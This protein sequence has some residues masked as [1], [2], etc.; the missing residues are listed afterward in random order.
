MPY[1]S[2]E[3]FQWSF[4]GGPWALGASLLAGAVLIGLSYRLTLVRLPRAARLALSFLRFVAV[5]LILACICRPTV[6]RQV[7]SEGDEKPKVAVVF[8]E[9][10]S[11]DVKSLWGQSRRDK[12]L[13]YWA[14]R[15]SRQ[16]DLYELHTYAFAES[17][18]TSEKPG[19]SPPPATGGPTD[20]PSEALQTHLYR[21]VAD[22]SERFAAQGY[23]AVI[24]LTDGMD[25]SGESPQQALDALHQ[26][27]LPHAFVALTTPL[28]SLPFVEITKLEAP[29]T[30]QV[31]TNVPVN[32]LVQASG[33]AANQA[34]EVVVQRGEQVVHRRKVPHIG[35]ASTQAIQFEV[36]VISQETFV[37]EARVQSGSEVLGSVKWSVQGLAKEKPVVLLYQGA[38]DWGTRHLRGVFDR[39]DNAEMEV[40]FASGALPDVYGWNR[41][42]DKFPGPTELA[43]FNVVI[44]LN[45]NAQQITPRMESTLT[46]FVRNGGG[47][48][49]IGGDPASAAALEQSAL[50]KLLPVEPG[51]QGEP[52]QPG[53]TKNMSALQRLTES[54]GPAAMR[55][56][57][58]GSFD[59][60][61][62]GQQS[63]Q[64]GAAL[65]PI[66]LTREGIESPIFHYAVSDGRPVASMLPGVESLLP[67]GQAKPGARVL[68][69]GGR[70]QIVLATQS[71]GR[72]LAAMLATDSLWRWRMSLES[73]SEAYDKFW[74][75]LVGYLAARA[76]RE[77]AWLLDSAVCVSNKAVEAQFFLPDGCRFK[78]EELTFAAEAPD[79]AVPL[80]LAA[81]PK[82]QTYRTTLVAKPKTTYRLVA[83]PKAQPDQVVAEAFLTGRADLTRQELRVLKPDPA[84]LAE[85]A[86]ASGGVVIDPDRSFDWS[87]WLPKRPAEIIR[88]ERTP[89]WHSP[90]IFVGMLLLLLGELLIRRR[91]RMI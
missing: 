8:D 17:L 18:R 21:S 42:E 66:T 47:L 43:R 74:R 27:A 16:H 79:Q 12:A 85:M 7:R 45:L 24:C 34:L 38:M 31:G 73:N 11:V 72:G 39:A 30:V 26:T 22:W 90:W 69:E 3:Q 89:L 86:A 46:E 44:L 60:T 1:Q 49:A 50:Q 36:P 63:R 40:R 55:K 58:P 76:R 25:T 15:L 59:A 75:Q 14:S 68:A 71:F 81:A 82:D 9:S 77:P 61:F 64:R 19:D 28:P 65:T 5:A 41:S 78:L 52:G 53:A 10:G 51:G 20:P 70:S 4:P 80:S 88:T 48:L 57:N 29:S 67:V 32:M 35:H 62:I 37:Y 84:L 23:D 6:V 54:A 91:Y 13:W 33:L 87:N 2:F 83:R 56:A